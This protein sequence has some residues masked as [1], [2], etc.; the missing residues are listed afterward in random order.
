MER[1]ARVRQDRKRMSNEP[2]QTEADSLLAMEKHADT[3]RPY[4]YPLMGGSLSV[5]LTS[6]D[7][8]E[9]FF[10]DAYR[11]RIELRKA[12]HQNRA[13]S[14]V[15]LA[16]LD[17][18]ATAHTNPDGVRIVGDHIHLYREGYGDKWA[19]PIPE[20]FR[21]LPDPMSVFE[22]FMVFCNVTVR[23]TLQGGAFR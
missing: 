8:R 11:G 15:V 10:L 20:R 12:T 3:S 13:R 19:S 4:V 7:Q 22:E 21:G 1:F 5:P 18:G 14:I 9:R 23:P 16:R 2:T 6:V 17:L